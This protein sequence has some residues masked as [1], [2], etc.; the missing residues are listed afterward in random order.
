M[1]TDL[2]EACSKRLGDA[3]RF[4][5]V[6]LLGEVDRL[7]LLVLL[8]PGAFFL[9]VVVLLIFSVDALAD[10]LSTKQQGGAVC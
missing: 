3:S 2:G 1:T 9:L 10:A 5:E 7:A 4:G 6:G 8:L